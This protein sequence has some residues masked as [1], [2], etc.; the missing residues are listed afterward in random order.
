MFFFNIFGFIGGYPTSELS[1]SLLSPLFLR[2]ERLSSVCGFITNFT[3]I[4]TF[5]V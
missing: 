1:D 4:Q 2:G 5:V 3:L